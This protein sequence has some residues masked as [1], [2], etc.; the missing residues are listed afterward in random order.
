M[1]SHYLCVILIADPTNQIGKPDIIW[2]FNHEVFIEHKKVW[3]KYMNNDKDILCLFLNS[4]KDLDVDYKLDMTN[5]TITVKGLHS[6]DGLDIPIKVF[7]AI[8]DLFL[9]DYILGTTSSS[10]WVLSKLKEELMYNT[11]KDKV[12]KGRSFYHT[13]VP[14]VSGSGIVMTKDVVCILIKSYEYL[15]LNT[16]NILST[17]SQKILELTKIAIHHDPISND[18]LIGLLLDFNNIELLDIKWWYDF[19]HNTIDNI[20]NNLKITDSNN[21]CHY[22]IR[23]DANRLYYDTIIMNKLYDYYYKDR[24]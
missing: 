6:Y 23:N 3:Q 10:F 22:R 16:Y 14:F 8:N 11:P 2:R 12:Y 1:N 5:N 24:I 21:I 15:E 19:D 20:H 9:Y 13:P 17:E 7:K 18:V 4:D